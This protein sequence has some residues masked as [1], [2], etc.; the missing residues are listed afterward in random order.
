MTS[1]KQTVA[2]LVNDE[3]NDET[4]QS[5]PQG[6]YGIDSRELRQVRLLMEDRLLEG[7]GLHLQKQAG[8]Q[9]QP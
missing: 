9:E 6:D 3:C 2:E 5:P 7:T 8:P 1:R 4:N